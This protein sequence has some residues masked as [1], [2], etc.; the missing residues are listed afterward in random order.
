M[1]CCRDAARLASRSL[2][3][4]LSV[5]ERM[6]LRL[7]LF[8]CRACSRYER[9]I[10]AIRSALAEGVAR[11]SEIEAMGRFSLS[12]EDREEINRALAAAGP[13]GS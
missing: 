5:R 1:L 10:R 2:D 3:A 11:M 8:M 7:H 6:G 12:P 13:E 9:Q 4:S